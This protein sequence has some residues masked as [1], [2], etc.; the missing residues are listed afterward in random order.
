LFHPCYKFERSKGTRLLQHARWIRWIISFVFNGSCLPLFVSRLS[1]KSFRLQ[2]LR[3]HPLEPIKVSIFIS[4]A[5]R[6]A[7]RR[8][9]TPVITLPNVRC[10]LIQSAS[11]VSNWGENDFRTLC[12]CFRVRLKCDSTILFLKMNKALKF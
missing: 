2:K 3:S 4:L 6:L 11:R 5:I 12:V 9:L 1:T 7:S 10:S 8:T